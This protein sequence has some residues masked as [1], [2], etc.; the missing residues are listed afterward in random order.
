MTVIADEATVMADHVR[1]VRADYHRRVSRAAITGCDLEIMAVIDGETRCWAANPDQTIVDDRAISFPTPEGVAVVRFAGDGAPAIM[2]TLTVMDECWRRRDGARR[3]MRR[4]GFNAEEPR[5]MRAWD[6]ETSGYAP[7]T[8]IMIN[9]VGIFPPSV[10][11]VEWS[12]TDVLHSSGD[13]LSA[14]AG[15]RVLS[16]A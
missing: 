9:S 15:E 3:E 16:L 7:S 13:V 2:P 8:M 11:G 10:Q 14:R 12:E 5:M 6:D 4:I 1:S